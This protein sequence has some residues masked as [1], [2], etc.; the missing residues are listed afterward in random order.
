GGPTP[1]GTVQFM[2]DGNNLGTAVP[3][4]AGGTAT[5]AAVS[6]LGA[7]THN[8]VAR[9][10]GDLRYAPG[11]R[12]TTPTAPQAHLG[13]G[14]DHLDHAVRPPP[15]APPP[16]LP[17]V[18]AGRPGAPPHPPRS[19]DP[20]P[21]RHDGQPGRDLPDHGGLG[22]HPHRPQLRLPRRQLRHRHA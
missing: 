16:P 22:R 4:A 1:T 12:G 7:G 14:A 11:P 17:G 2:V 9:Y 10:S 3:L 6:N 8:V 5:S 21:P 18:R 13:V 15:P 19:P 20:P